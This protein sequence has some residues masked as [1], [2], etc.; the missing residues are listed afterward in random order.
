MYTR[1]M[2][3]VQGTCTLYKYDVHIVPCST[4]VC[5]CIPPCAS[6]DSS[7]RRPHGPTVEHRRAD[8]RVA[9]VARGVEGRGSIVVGPPH[10]GPAVEQ[11][12]AD[13]LV[14]ALA[15]SQEGRGSIVGFPPHV[16]PAVE[17]QRTPVF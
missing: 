3:L 11:Q 5:L 13:V 6:T 7:A 12:L 17:R 14:A 10:V 16:G 2:Y 15:R 4:C 8:V 1:T 9:V